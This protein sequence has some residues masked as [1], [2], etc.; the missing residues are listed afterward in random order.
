MFYVAMVFEYSLL[1]T[2]INVAIV[3]TVLLSR[4]INRQTVSRGCM[5]S[6]SELINN[7]VL[8]YSIKSNW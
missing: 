4:V 6:D 5:I 2:V 7:T 8:A 1:S 3:F